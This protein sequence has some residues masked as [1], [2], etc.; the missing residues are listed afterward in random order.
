MS[1][2]P[3]ETSE[4]RAARDELLKAESA[5]REH[6]E[7]VAQL[8]RKLPMG[9]K[10]KEDYV[11]DELD[12]G[13]NIKQVR[14]SELFSPGRDTL[15]LYGFMFGPGDEAPCPMCTSMLDS[16]DG[17]SPHVT[18]RINLAVVARS[19]IERVH[20]FAKSRDWNRLRL[21][22]SA[23]N[24]YQSDYLAE[25]EKGNQMPMGNVFV[26]RD[27]IIHHFWGTELL[28][29]PMP[30]E[31]GGESRHMDHAWPVWNIFDCTPEGRGEDWY[32]ALKY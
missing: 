19:P 2:F 7:R 31:Q 27:G 13:G 22:S 1:N 21:L 25:D 30:K 15:F 11:F 9:G 24:S 29:S 10:V 32:P 12:D 6:A 5:L 17:A 4:Y 26:R 23:G 8:R 18:Q 16:M 3:N 20:K 28:Y 14:L